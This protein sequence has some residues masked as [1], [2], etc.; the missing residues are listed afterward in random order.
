MLILAIAAFNVERMG[1]WPVVSQSL[2]GKLKGIESSSPANAQ[3]DAS[4]SAKPD[5]VAEALPSPQS[6]NDVGNAAAIA[7]PEETK[8]EF[9]KNDVKAPVA[10]EKPALPEAKPVVQMQDVKPAAVLPVITG[11][12]KATKPVIAAAKNTLVFNV[13]KDSWI[14]VRDAHTVLLSRMVK[15]G[16][17]EQLEVTQPVSLIVGNAAGVDI[18]FRGVP[19]ETK[20][21][22]KSNVARLSLK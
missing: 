20:T 6:S 2:S 13:R 16:S 15:A 21:D 22:A 18:E 5:S 12:S 1:G 10:T 17:T 8:S 7:K 3:S 11:D 9:P 4:T 19:V 14:E